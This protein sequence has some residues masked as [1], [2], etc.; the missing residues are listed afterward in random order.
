MLIKTAAQRRTMPPTPTPSSGLSPKLALAGVS[1]IATATAAYLLLRRRRQRTCVEVYARAEDGRLTPA[2]VR[3]AMVMCTGGRRSE[4]SEAGSKVTL[5]VFVDGV[6]STLTQP[7]AICTAYRVLTSYPTYFTRVH[8]QP[9]PSARTYPI[10][11]ARL[12]TPITVPWRESMQLALAAT[13]DEGLSN[14]GASSGGVIEC[15]SGERLISAIDALVAAD[16]RTVGLALGPP[17]SSL[18]CWISRWISPQVV[19]HSA[20]LVTSEQWACLR[21]WAER[22]RLETALA[23]LCTLLHRLLDRARQDGKDERTAWVGVWMERPELAVNALGN[24]SYWGLRE[25]NGRVAT[26]AE[27][28]ACVF[29]APDRAARYEWHARQREPSL[30][31]RPVVRLSRAATRGLLEV[32]VTHAPS[33]SA[34]ADEAPLAGIVWNP[35]ADAHAADGDGATGSRSAFSRARLLEIFALVDRRVEASVEEDGVLV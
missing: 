3:D 6:A 13:S 29:T 30:A 4:E 23:E 18:S 22:I 12:P 20:A 21:F 24:E 8:P 25:P 9:D 2:D 27:R 10:A 17:A 5:I 15:M 7:L 11:P 1:E 34:S 33:N 14:V 28:M 35:P 32:R 19:A 31:P 26:D 16:R